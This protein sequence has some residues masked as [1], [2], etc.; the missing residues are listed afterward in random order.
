MSEYSSDIVRPPERV[1]QNWLIMQHAGNLTLRLDAGQLDD[2]SADA[3]DL[4]LD[5]GELQIALQLSGSGPT[6]TSIVDSL[7]RYT[8]LTPISDPEV[9]EYAKQ[10]LE[11]LRSGAELHH[12][13]LFVGD[14]PARVDGEFL[15][16][17]AFTYPI[18]DAIRSGQF[19]EP[20]KL[21]LGG[22]VQA[23][24]ALLVVAASE[25]ENE[26]AQLAYR[27]SQYNLNQRRT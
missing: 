2:I 22:Y 8:R 14:E 6:A 18:Y 17:G 27:V 16:I 9:Y 13:M 3:A 21:P 25:R 7:K 4:L 24:L 20:I 1:H 15:R 23:A 11:L 26:D 19:G 12:A 5:V 10:Q